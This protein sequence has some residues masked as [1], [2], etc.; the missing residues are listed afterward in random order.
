M[1]CACCGQAISACSCV[2]EHCP[3]TGRCAQHCRCVICHQ[4]RLITSR[5][6]QQ[7]MALSAWIA[8]AQSSTRDLPLAVLQGG[9]G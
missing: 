1:M 3:E 6:G 5:D 2:L 8:L 7:A 9:Q 4:W